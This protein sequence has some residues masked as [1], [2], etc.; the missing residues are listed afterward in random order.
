MQGRTTI[1]VAHRLSTIVDADIIY[2]VAG[3]K[4][5]EH[6]RHGELLAKGGAYS[7]LYALQAIEEPEPIRASA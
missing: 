1:V 7:R 3:G 4:L 2:V 5:V 6:G